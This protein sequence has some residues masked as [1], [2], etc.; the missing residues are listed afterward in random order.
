MSSSLKDLIFF[1]N[2]E[3]YLALNLIYFLIFSIYTVGLLIRNRIILINLDC[4]NEMNKIHN[5]FNISMNILNIFPNDQ[6]FPDQITSFRRMIYNCSINN[7]KSSFPIPNG[8]SHRRRAYTSSVRQTFYYSSSSAK[9]L[10]RHAEIRFDPRPDATD[11]HE[12]CS[13]SR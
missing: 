3:N 8:V 12:S 7:C 5:F 2:G 9:L 10:S 1:E 11:R 6:T 4:L 13:A